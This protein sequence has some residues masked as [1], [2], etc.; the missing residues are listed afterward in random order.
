[1]KIGEMSFDQNL[2][3]LGTDLGN[4]YV[5]HHLSS[6]DLA[7]ISKL[8]EYRDYAPGEMILEEGAENNRL[9]IL[10]Q[11]AVSIVSAGEKIAELKTPGNILGEMSLIT[12]KKCSASNVAAEQTRLLVIEVEKLPLLSNPLQ[13]VLTNAFNR[14]FASILSVKLTVTN[15]KARQHEIINRELQVA[16]RALELASSDKINE[17]SAHQRVVFKKLNA[18][19]QNDVAPIRDQLIALKGM[20]EHQ[21]LVIDAIS[22]RMQQVFKDLEPLAKSFEAEGSLR[23]KRVLLVEDDVNEQIN[24]KM[25]LGGTGVDFIVL[26]DLESAKQAITEGR[27]DIICVNGN[28]VELIA[29]ARALYADIKYVFITTDPISKHFQ[30]LKSYPELSTIVARHPTD[31]TFTVRNIA[32]T[33]R[34]LSSQDIFGMEKYLNW[35]TEIVEQ[36]IT[37]SDQRHDVIS[38]FDEYLDS[39]AIR[40]GLKRKSSRVAEELLMNAIYD[41]PTDSAGKSLYNHMDR[42]IPLNL[43]S[44]E[45]ATFRYACDG[46]FLAVSVVDRFGALTRSTIL[47]Y[48]E[49]CF[50]QQIGESA[51]DDKGGGG[52]GL[53]QIIQSSSLTAFNINPGLQTEVIAL[54]NINIQMEKVSTHPSFH[55]FSLGKNE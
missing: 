7:E 2:Q 55:Y 23:D 1:M 21:P 13:E 47:N 34:K 16:K 52:N 50:N 51:G 5:G 43:K 53:F 18:L 19:L 14:L 11:G 24:A 54:L 44:D 39:I 9:F 36:I 25:S 15:E 41:A 38:K 29:F 42:S 26:S 45:F 37:S 22:A 4:F 10:V 48:L 27:F 20:N 8:S 32:T 12:G 30:T 17:L 6:S 31:R 28:F 3:T 46:T 35:G 33:I 49:R 40:G